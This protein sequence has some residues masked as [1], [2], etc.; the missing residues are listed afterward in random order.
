MGLVGLSTYTLV[1]YRYSTARDGKNHHLLVILKIKDQIIKHCDVE[2]QDHFTFSRLLKRV[3][4]MMGGGGGG[5]VNY[6]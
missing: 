2:D 3:V 6:K 1:V 5:G 4:V